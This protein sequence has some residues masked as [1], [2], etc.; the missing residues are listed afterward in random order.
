MLDPS[1]ARYPAYMLAGT[2]NS[3]DA[4]AGPN[5]QPHHL[6]TTAPAGFPTTGSSASHASQSLL[7]LVHQVQLLIRLPDH[8]TDVVVRVA[9]PLKEFAQAGQALGSSDSGA[10]EGMI[11]EE[12]G[13]A[14][15]LLARVVG[16]LKVCDWGLLHG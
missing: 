16:T 6:A 7:T 12:L 13:R 1:L 10:T 11:A 4:R 3:V 14:R 2:I 9:V 8:D 5:A 15:D